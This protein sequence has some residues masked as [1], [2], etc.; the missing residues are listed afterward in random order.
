MVKIDK[1]VYIILVNY[2]GSVDTIECIES[3]KVI[4]HSNY[5][6]VVVDNNSTDENKKLLERY[7]N[8]A[9]II[10]LDDNLG[11]SGANNKGIEEALKNNADYILLLNNDTIVE[12]DFLNVL[13]ETATANNNKCAVTGKINYYYS[14]D[15]IWYGGGEISK[16]KGNAYHLNENRS[17]DEY[18]NE[19]SE[20][21]FITGCMILIPIGVIKNIGLMSE[22]YFLYFEDVDFSQKIL[23]AGF[24]LYYD[25]K[26]VIYHKVSASTGTVSNLFL[27]YYCRN[28]LI[29]IK[30]NLGFI[31]RLS[32]YVVFS[33]A[34]IKN[35]ISKKEN[36]Y[37]VKEGVMD[38]LKNKK[39]K[40]NFK[41]DM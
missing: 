23:N 6:I 17:S 28:R 27:Y 2:N 8:I 4:E 30:N 36:K 41:Q 22:D 40:K 38:F 29:F 32:A 18:G 13:V 12:K 3:L 19:F 31:N 16:W 20:V 39:G 21:T 10:F 37:I 9:K 35:I 26:S 5:E 1:K 34:R 11:F 15:K 14:K 25:P 7:S 33:L 24:K